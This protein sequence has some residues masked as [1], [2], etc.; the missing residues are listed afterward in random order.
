M[1]QWALKGFPEENVLVENK[2][3][4]D[5]RINLQAQKAKLDAQ[6]KDSQ[7]ASIRLPKLEDFVDLVR[8]KLSALDFEAKRLALDMLNVKVWLDGDSVEIT[9]AI[10]K[11]D[12]AIVTTQC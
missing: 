9:G 10:P 12:D 8:Q 1:L 11:T 2:R 4:N 5:K 6:I 7:K 3:I